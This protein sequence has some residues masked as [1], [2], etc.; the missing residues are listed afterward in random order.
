MI[1][2]LDNKTGL[3]GI[4]VFGNEIDSMVKACKILDQTNYDFIDIN[5]GPVNKI[6]KQYSVVLNA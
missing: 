3:V 6:V 2:E 1:K 4:Q 5:M